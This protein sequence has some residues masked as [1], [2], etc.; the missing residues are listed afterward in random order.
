MALGDHGGLFVLIR[1][2]SDVCC[3]VVA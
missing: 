3:C 1:P 2:A